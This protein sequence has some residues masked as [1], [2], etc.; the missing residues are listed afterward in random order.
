MIGV[1][2]PDITNNHFTRLV[3]ELQLRLFEKGYTVEICNTNERPDLEEGYLRTL[4]SQQVSGLIVI[5]G[6]RCL[7]PDGNVPIV[8]LDRR[9][10]D[11]EPEHREQTEAGCVIESDN[12][13]G[14]S[15]ATR[16]LLSIGCRSL[17]LLRPAH[18]DY[19]QTMRMQGVFRALSE[20]GFPEDTAAQIPFEGLS[21]PAAKK[22]VKTS[23][24]KGL[25]FD[26]IFCL[27]DVHAIG[28]LTALR[29]AGISVPEKC[30][31]I[32]F[33]DSQLA[34]IWQPSLTSVHQYTDEMAARAVDVLISL[35]SGNENIPTYHRLAVRLIERETT[36]R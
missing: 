24:N 2:V 13:Q 12:E 27:T 30:A 34:P 15:L 28:A 20:A 25:H 23:L 29:E 17:A 5:S 35:L 6:R 33:D 1:I 22:A 9:P 4:H 36:A 32:G 8:Y 3:L 26:G 18:P 16:K 7:L 14:G 31:V 11:F 10:E 21:I 19:N